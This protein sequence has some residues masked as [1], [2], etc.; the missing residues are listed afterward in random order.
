MKFIDIVKKQIPYWLVFL[1]IILLDLVF[2]INWINTKYVFIF[3]LGYLIVMLVD[4]Y[5]QS[6]KSNTA[7]NE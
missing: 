7:T 3:A 1:I 6:S 4:D 5:R 2:N